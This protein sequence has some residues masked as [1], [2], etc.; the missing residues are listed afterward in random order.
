VKKL[1]YLQ[2][3]PIGKSSFFI[4]AVTSPGPHPHTDA[5]SEETREKKM[6][7][8]PMR[9]FSKKERKKERERRLTGTEAKLSP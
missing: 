6:N 3:I 9:K 8:R 4:Q 2:V 7:T 1:P 5:T